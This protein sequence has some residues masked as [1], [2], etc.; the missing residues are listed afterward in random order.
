M[1]LLTE[2]EEV[3]NN[4]NHNAKEVGDAATKFE[5]NREFLE[6]NFELENNGSDNKSGSKSKNDK[7]DDNSEN[8]NQPI[9]KSHLENNSWI[10]DCTTKNAK[11]KLI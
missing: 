9:Y 2:C 7:L 11:L 5:T 1:A 3:K 6:K 8:L 4:N 10:N